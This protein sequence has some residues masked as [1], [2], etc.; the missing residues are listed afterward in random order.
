[1]NKEDSSQDQR[2]LT[3]QESIDLALQYHASG[4]LAEA[5][6]IYQ[7][8]LQADPNQPV[9][10]H[11]LGVIA[12]QV[13]KHAAAVDLIAKALD[14]KPDYAEAHINL[15]NALQKLGRLD[16]AAASFYKALDSKPGYAEALYNLGNVFLELGRLDEA[17][18]RYHKTLDVNPD[19]AEAHNNLGLAFQDLGRV[20]EAAASYHKALTIN[21]G[22]APAHNNY[23]NALNEQGRLEDAVSSY[24]TALSLNPD[25]A[26]AHHNLGNVFR[27]LGRLKD[28]AASYRQAIALKPDYGVAYQSLSS[29]MGYLSDFQDVLSLSD[30]SLE[31]LPSSR[32]KDNGAVWEAR[33]YILSYHPDLPVEKIYAEFVRWGDA[34]VGPK[35]IPKHANDRTPERRLKI[36]YVSPDFNRHTSRFYFE[37]LFENHDRSTCE[38]FAYSNVGQADDFTE[39]FRTLFD[40]WRDI[41]PMTDEAAADLIRR[42]GIDILVDACNHMRDDR[43]GVFALKPSPVQVTWLGA[44]W[45]TG[46]PTMDYVFFDRHEAPEGTLAREAI[47]RLPDTFI[48]FRPKDNITEVGKAPCLAKG[49]V[50]FG[51]YGRTERLNHGTFRV[52]GRIFSALPDARLILDFKAFGDPETRDYYA[53]VL[54]QHGVDVSRVT[55]RYSTNVWEAL[56]DIDIMFDSFPH[57]GGTMSYDSICKGVPLLTLA[58]RPPLGR[59]GA[60][61]MTNLGLEDWVA[62]DEDAFFAK[63][64][65]LAGDCGYL[66]EIRQS[67]RERLAVSPIRDEAGYVRAVEAA[68]RKMWRRWCAGEP[69]TPFDVARE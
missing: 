35:P 22:F 26:E 18:E 33:L 14:I 16:E 7:Q 54:N 17:V 45:T 56:D 36:G 5:E 44:A 62:E 64:V 58:S 53:D 2:T 28:A 47:V 43:L 40:H 68:Y 52:W 12:H 67:L 3:I 46:L 13:G 50:T 61:I 30:K 63:A 57:N 19:Y 25:Y 21:P 48:T 20:D 37:P 51:Y 41:R 10:L 4:R 27:D 24:R 8:I 31:L 23:G 11:F 32:I 38:L 42:D 59:I 39:R 55:M 65:D 49:H 15:G 29:A 69:A 66:A 6:S 34:Q 60:S 9:A 1:M